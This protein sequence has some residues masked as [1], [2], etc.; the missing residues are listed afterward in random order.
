MKYF[1]KLTRKYLWQSS[2]YKISMMKNFSHFTRKQLWQSL[3][4][5]EAASWENSQNSQENT[6]VRFPLLIKFQTEKSR[7]IHKE[8]PE[9]NISNNFLIHLHF[10]IASL[11]QNL[12]FLD[13]LHKVFLL[14]TGNSFSCFNSANVISNVVS[15]GDGLRKKTQNLTRQGSSLKA[16]TVDQFP[17]LI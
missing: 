16:V 8:T 4:F 5:K 11:I 1:S 15:C 7:K 17:S 3:V 6:F 9:H 13:H 12:I 2:F 14:I 10:L